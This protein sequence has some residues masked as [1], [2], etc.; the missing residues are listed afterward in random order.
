[1]KDGKLTEEGFMHMANKMTNGDAD[2]LKVAKDVFGE[3]ANIGDADPC[4]AAVKIGFCVKTNA[5]KRKVTLI[6]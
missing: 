6:P 4:E 2:K 3:C 1:M 5:E